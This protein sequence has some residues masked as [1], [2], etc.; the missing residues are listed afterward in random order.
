MLF[1]DDI[2][3]QLIKAVVAVIIAG[4]MTISMTKFRYSLRRVVIVYGIY[5]VYAALII[6]L[7]LWFRDWVFLARFVLLAITLP[8]LAI[9]HLLSEGTLFQ[10]IFNTVLQVDIAYILTNSVTLLNRVFGWTKWQDIAVRVAIGILAIFLEC[11][12]LR[13]RYLHTTEI[14]RTSWGT[15]MLIPLSFTVLL[16]VFS[17]FPAYITLNPPGVVLFLV[18]AL[19]MGFVCIVVFQSLAKS[20]SL[21]SAQLEKE[22]IERQLDIQKRFY[23]EKLG[24]EEKLRALRHD[25]RGHLNTLSALLDADQA[26]EAE[27]YLNR[28]IEHTRNWQESAFH[29]EEEGGNAV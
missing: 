1:E 4:G 3:Y 13:R 6:A 20:R 16:F 14:L 22:N 10:S 12:F 18:T 8:G 17:M 5:L 9:T 25:M 28:L 27:D 26:A 23:E 15:L 7:L 29:D 24:S 2:V 19:V 21:L 11:R